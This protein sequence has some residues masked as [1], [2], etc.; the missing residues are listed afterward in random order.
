MTAPALEGVPDIPTGH[1]SFQPLEVEFL[2]FPTLSG[3]ACGMDFPYDF[4][5]ICDVEPD[6]EEGEPMSNLDNL[7]F[8]FIKCHAQFFTLLSDLLLAV[9]QIFLV[10]MDE[11]EIIHIPTISF[12]MQDFFQK[13]VDV[14]RHRRGKQLTDLT[15]QPQAFTLVRWCVGIKLLYEILTQTDQPEVG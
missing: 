3:N 15:A 5:G 13:V 7:R 12:D 9:P 6:L 11:I 10:F 14:T 1:L 2:Q 4:P 8:P